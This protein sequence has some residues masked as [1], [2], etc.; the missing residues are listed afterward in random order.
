M[1]DITSDSTN[2]REIYHILDT[3]LIKRNELS[4]NYK[5]CTAESYINNPNENDFILSQNNDNKIAFT[6]YNKFSPIPK[7][8]FSTIEKKES[9][10]KYKEKGSYKKPKCLVPESPM[11]TPNQKYFTPVKLQSNLFGN[12]STCRKLNFNE[13]NESPK[14]DDSLGKE[15]SSPDK[16]NNYLRSLENEC[17]EIEKTDNHNLKTNSN[18]YLNLNNKI[19]NNSIINGKINIS[20]NLFF[21]GNF[22]EKLQSLFPQDELKEYQV[23]QKLNYNI[24]NN[25]QIISNNPSKSKIGNLGIFTNYS[26][27]TPPKKVQSNLNC[28][29]NI[30]YNNNCSKKLNFITNTENQN[31]EEAKDCFNNNN[32]TEEEEE[33][34]EDNTK[35]D[36]QEESSIVYFLY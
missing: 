34:N 25:N 29:N 22:N 18:I 10:F 3:N 6:N 11:K 17:K 30:F 33:E 31:D 5:V 24:Y 13:I 32:Q 1:S 27:T 4:Q 35:K 7:P 12:L 14:E 8:D 15:Q 16:K 2:T 21:K 26:L 28:F 36:V 23:K 20:D 9:N 19:S